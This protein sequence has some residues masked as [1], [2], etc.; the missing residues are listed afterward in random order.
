MCRMKGRA[1]IHMQQMRQFMR[2]GRPAHVGRAEDQPPA[3]ADRTGRS[4]T[5]PAAARIAHAHRRDDQ[6][7]F[8]RQFRRFGLQHRP[9]PRHQPAL[10][11][12]AD[13]LRRPTEHQ[14]VVRQPDRTRRTL[15]PADA[16]GP[17][18]QRKCRAIVQQG[19]R[20]LRR[21]LRTHPAFMLLRPAQ[22]ALQ[23]RPH[24]HR[25]AQFAARAVDRQPVG[26]RPCGPAH[27]H[28]HRHAVDQDRD[29]GIRCPGRQDDSPGRPLPPP[30]RSSRAPIPARDAPLP[31]RRRPDNA[32]RATARP[33]HAGDR[34]RC[35]AAS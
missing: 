19:H 30:P 23:V 1:M 24:R 18:L 2:H 3:I 34:R 27:P 22:C 17:S 32:S 12:R 28:R 15:D 6:A 31:G 13:R 26:A 25:Q 20:R 7:M 10:H 9:R 11:P 33:L 4:A 14:P 21:H 29:V 16:D 35:A 5:A 8:A